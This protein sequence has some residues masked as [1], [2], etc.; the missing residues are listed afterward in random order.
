[1]QGQ[2]FKTCATIAH[3]QNALQTIDR[4]VSEQVEI[5][6]AHKGMFNMEGHKL[7]T[8]EVLIEPD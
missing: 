5:V 6:K 4:M 1:M 2:T 7:T 3:V 8:V